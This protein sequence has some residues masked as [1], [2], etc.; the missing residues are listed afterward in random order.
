MF[1][2]IGTGCCLVLILVFVGCGD[3]PVTITAPPG[4]NP[5]TIIQTPGDYFPMTLG[6]WWEYA[7][8]VNMIEPDDILW[9]EGSEYLEVISVSGDTC[10]VEKTF[11]LWVFCGKV[12]KDTLVTV[13]TLTYLVNTDSVAILSPDT[14]SHK[15][16]DFPLELGKTWDGWTVVDMNA[17]VITPAGL[18]EGCAAISKYDEHQ[19]CYVYYYYSPGT[20]M[21][22]KCA[23]NAS[24]WPDNTKFNIVFEL[25]G[26]IY[27]PLTNCRTLTDIFF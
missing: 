6:D 24:P 1:A 15:Y 27:Y 11:S 3:N 4:D 13:S 10:I 20:G 9:E 23:L 25:T 26:S 7:Y 14:V 19:N 8:S 5:V 12:Q 18:F 2:N 21:I 17:D 22:E 16:L